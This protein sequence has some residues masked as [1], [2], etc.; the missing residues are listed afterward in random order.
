M[1]PG[2]PTSPDHSGYPVTFFPGTTN[3]AEAQRITVAAGQ[4]IGDLVMAMSPIKVARVEG[5]VVDGDGRPMGNGSLEMLQSNGSNNF[6]SGQS[7]RPDGTFMFASLTPGEYVFRAQS[8]GSNGDVAMLKLTVGGEDIT[9]LRLVAMPPPKVSGRIVV[10]PSLTVPAAFSL[11]ASSDEQRM[12]GGMRPAR[13]DD[14][15]SFELDHHTR[16]QPH[17][18]DQPAGG[19]GDPIRPRQQ[20]RRDGRWVRGE[21]GRE[22]HRRRRGAD[23]QA[24]LGLRPGDQRARRAGEGLH[25]ADV[26]VRQ[27]TLEAGQPVPAPARPDQDGRFKTFGVVPADY[28]II[29]IDKLEPGQWTDPDFLETIRS[30]GHRVHHS[31]GRDTN[32]GSEGSIQHLEIA[33]F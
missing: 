26:P 25:A 18:R 28:Y 1:G 2:D 31:G 10:D 7:L 29:A 23:Q 20:R 15:L 9:G 33:D 17:Q 24:R 21:A 11:M 16:T 5:I 3:E 32:G 14:D 8:T 13:V 12:P 19:L 4:T 27:Q 6:M 22:H 30:K